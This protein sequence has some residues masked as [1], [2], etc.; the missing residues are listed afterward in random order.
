MT[1]PLCCHSPQSRITQPASRSLRPRRPARRVLG[2]PPSTTRLTPGR[3]E[4]APRVSLE[5]AGRHPPKAVTEMRRGAVGGCPWLRERGAKFSGPGGLTP[6]CLERKS[7]EALGRDETP[8]PSSPLGVLLPGQDLALRA[9]K[10][11]NI[12]KISL[13]SII[14]IFIAK[15]S[16]E[17]EELFLAV[18]IGEKFRA[19]DGEKYSI[20][21]VALLQYLGL[22]F[23]Q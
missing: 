17:V 12:C 21:M 4:R 16:M 9:L 3:S 5:T 7:R 18:Y 15:R 6:S 23:I 2:I 14:H 22:V 11:Y 1:W 10:F 19:H 20:N 8:P 13:C